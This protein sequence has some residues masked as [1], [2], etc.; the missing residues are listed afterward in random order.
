MLE[1]RH[2]RKDFEL[3]PDAVNYAARRFIV[4]ALDAVYVDKKLGDKARTV[5][6]ERAKERESGERAK[7]RESARA[8]V[9]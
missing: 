7:E 6:G 9:L 4:A 5:G 1:R 2:C 3:A 8:R